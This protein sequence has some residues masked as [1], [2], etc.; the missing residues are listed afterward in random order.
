MSS[1][2]DKKEPAYPLI[3]YTYNSDKILLPHTKTIEETLKL[4]Q[5]YLEMPKNDDVELTTKWGSH[6]V[7]LVAHTWPYIAGAVDEIKVT[8][9]EKGPLSP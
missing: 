7:R 5:Y 3:L 1:S 4:L 2:K 9:Y 6:W 8:T